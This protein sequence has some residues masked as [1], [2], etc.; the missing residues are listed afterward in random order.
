MLCEEWYFSILL[1]RL[2]DFLLRVCEGE[3]KLVFKLSRDAVVD[4]TEQAI[5]S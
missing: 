2:E 4:S 1:G 3:L 5:S